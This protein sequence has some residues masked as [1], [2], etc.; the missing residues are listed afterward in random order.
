MRK[1]LFVSLVLSSL[2]GV[3]AAQ[4]PPPQDQLVRS[5]AV[6]AVIWGMPAVNYDLMLQ[7]MLT[8]TNGKVGQVIYWGRPL[9]SKNQTLTPNPDALYFMVFY[10]TKD[11]PV[12]LDL[13]AGDSNGSFNGNIVTVWQKPLEDAG[14]LGVD[15]GKGGKFLILPPGYSGAKPDGYIALQSD[16]YGGY[17]LFR[18]NMKSH[19]AADVEKSIAYGKQ[20]KIYPLSQAANPPPTVFTDVKDVDYDS[21][22]RYNASFFEH[23]DRIVQSEPWIER[24]RVMIDTLKSLGIEKGKPYAPSEATLALLTKSIGE[25]RT[26]LAA[27]YDAGMPPFFTPTSRWMYPAPP[28]LIKAMQSG[29]ADPNVYP[30]DERGMAY[31]Y[32]F[33]GLKRLGTGQFYSI[34]IRDKDGDAFDGSKTYRLNVPANVPVEQYWSVTAYDRETHALIKGMSRASRSSQIPE[35]QKNADGSIDVYFGPHAPAG[36]DANWVPTDP[37]RKFELMARFYGPKP[38]FF[39]KKWVL[40]DVEKVAA[41]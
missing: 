25:A 6:E 19:S 38:E 4:T 30:V 39:E 31:T 3:A 26:W 10:D 7:E 18:A 15:K 41:Q 14:L 28:D 35:M 8:K 40:P 9:D 1:I 16:T 37:S 5:R 2:A 12:V 34:S 22:I 13:P 23:L 21:T 27:K 11:G 20:M 24:D 36:K 29:F 33:I 32:A 17:M